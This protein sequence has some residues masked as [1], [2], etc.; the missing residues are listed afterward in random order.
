M[1]DDDASSSTGRSSS[2]V[3]DTL[4]GS[5]TSGSC[6]LD[7]SIGLMLR[8]LEKDDSSLV[9]IDIDCK[10]MDV[11]AARCM[12][13]VLP[14]NTCLKRLRL[15]CGNDSR[16]LDVIRRVVSGLKGNSSVSHIEVHDLTMDRDTSSWM[17][18]SLATSK[19]LRHLSITKCRFL[20]SGLGV[21]FVGMQQNKRIQHLAFHWCDWDEHN[22]DIVATSL[23]FMNLL[24]LSLVGIYIAVDSWPFLLNKIKRSKELILLDLSWNSMDHTIISLL[25]KTMMIQQSISTLVLSSCGLDDQC[26]KELAKGLREY[27]TLRSLDLSKNNQM[28]S[29][30]VV[31]LKDLMKFNN[32]ITELIVNDCGLSDR[33]LNAIENSLR[34]NNSL[35]KSFLSE[36][37]SQAIFEMVDAIEKIDIGESTRSIVQALSFGSGSQSSY[38]EYAA[39][40]NVA[41]SCKGE[42][43]KKGKYVKNRLHGGV[44]SA[45]ITQA[46]QMTPEQGP[47]GFTNG[48]ETITYTLAFTSLNGQHEVFL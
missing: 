41:K 48:K 6:S 31:Y 22:I 13:L 14:D 10:L 20:G 43:T 25:T 11:D 18:Q 2:S 28:S 16:H 29:K 9:A 39:T 23:P 26:A 42:R 30:G 3:S 44:T 33:S 34:Y 45:P 15:I 27:S 36:A 46:D 32:T 40:R 24:S 5:T 4:D 12:S 7:D 17:A 47:D 38:G 35:L 37:A 1:E 21:L 19:S 8:R